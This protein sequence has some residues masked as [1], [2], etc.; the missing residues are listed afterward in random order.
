MDSDAY[1]SFVSVDIEESA[2]LFSIGLVANTQY[3]DLDDAPC[4]PGAARP[5][6]YRQGLEVIK[7]ANLFWKQQGPLAFVAHLGNVLADEN[8]PADLLA[9][10]QTYETERARGDC[11]TWHTLVGEHDLR[12][13]GRPGAPP[14][15]YG[16]RRYHSFSPSV[17]WRVIVLDAFAVSLAHAEGS[18][19][20]AAASRWREEHAS[21]HPARAQSAAGTSG[22]GQSGGAQPG[23]ALGEAQ[24]GW[25]REQLGELASRSE[26]AIVLCHL[27]CEVGAFAPRTLLWDYAEAQAALESAPSTTA[28]WIAC[29]DGAHADGAGSYARD[30]RGC[31]HLLLPAAVYSAVN[32]DAFGVLRVCGDDLRL[33]MCGRGPDEATRPEGWPTTLPLPLAQG[34]LSSGGAV[35]DAWQYVLLL[36]MMMIHAVAYMPLRLLGPRGGGASEVDERREEGDGRAAAPSEEDSLTT[37]L[38]AV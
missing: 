13:Y 24:L 23:G 21:K 15:P 35:A 36:C 37:P 18:D 22:A 1:A 9:A 3:A 32:E 29:A 17:G 19:A 25:L 26:R 33:Q 30:G 10:A 34:S 8:A 7:R 5:R 16:Q 27:A 12:C 14:A 28:A 20:H 31:H 38:D 11:A 2:P 4:A 6:R